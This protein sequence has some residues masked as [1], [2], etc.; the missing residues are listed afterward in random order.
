MIQFDQMIFKFKIEKLNHGFVEKETLLKAEFE[1]QKKLQTKQRIESFD[2]I[3]SK[4]QKQ[5]LENNQMFQTKIESL[6]AVS[7]LNHFNIYFFYLHLILL[8]DCSA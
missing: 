8:D 6:T 5:I 7:F 3:Q 4:F 2:A 1:E